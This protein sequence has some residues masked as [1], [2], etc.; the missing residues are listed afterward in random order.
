[1]IPCCPKC[2]QG[3]FILHFKEIEVDYCEHCRGLWL[4]HGELELLLESTRAGSH[5]PL[6]GFQKQPGFAPKK[7]K[8]LCPRCDAPLEEIQ[9]RVKSG[10]PLTL[11][12]CPKGHGLWF[13]QNELRQLL[14]AFPPQSGA[15]K[16]IALLDE[17]FSFQPKP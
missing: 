17:I 14:A 13:D 5:D 12:R 1:M 4:D 11:D 3:L 8:A 2:H 6:P 7:S 16:T 9:P 10:R 15:S